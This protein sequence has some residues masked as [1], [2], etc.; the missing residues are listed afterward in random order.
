MG[1][2]VLLDMVVFILLIN[3]GK[4]PEVKYS[5]RYFNTV[6]LRTT[7]VGV[8][9]CLRSPHVRA[10]VASLPFSTEGVAQFLSSRCLS[11]PKQKLFG[12]VLGQQRVLRQNICLK[13]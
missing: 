7:A 12:Q 11:L 13:G 3:S 1:S 4:T 2:A 6:R 8:S 5:W 10:A 9:D